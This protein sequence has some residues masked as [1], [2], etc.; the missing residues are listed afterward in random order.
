MALKELPNGIEVNYTGSA[1][2]SIHQRSYI[3]KR[4]LPDLINTT[5]SRATERVWK[6]DE[7]RALNFPRPCNPWRQMVEDGENGLC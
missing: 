1:V 6:R 3:V 5:R 7:V 2:T 4:S